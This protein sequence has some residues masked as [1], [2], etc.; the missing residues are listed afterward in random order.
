M[1][2][3]A[4]RDVANNFSYGDPVAGG[5][6]VAPNFEQAKANALAREGVT[7]NYYWLEGYGGVGPILM[8][9]P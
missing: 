5:T 9:N 6:C 3:Y 1:W 7:S 8:V 4:R 2:N